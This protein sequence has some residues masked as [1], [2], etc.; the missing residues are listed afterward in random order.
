MIITVRTTFE[1][2]H[3]DLWC[4]NHDNLNEVLSMN[5]TRRILKKIMP[6]P[7]ARIAALLRNTK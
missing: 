1:A 4:F 2:Q 5:K 3:L 6:M 7:G